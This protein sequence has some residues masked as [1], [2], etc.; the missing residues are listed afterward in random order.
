M[1]LSTNIM[2]GIFKTISNQDRTQVPFKA[3]KNWE[4]SDA[5]TLQTYGSGVMTAIKPNKNVY[6]GN[7]VPIGVIP[8]SLDYASNYTNVY[9]NEATASVLWYSLNHLYYKGDGQPFDTFG[10]ANH[11]QIYR[12]IY[13]DANVISLAQR[14]IG[15]GIKPGSFTFQASSS[16]Y[17]AEF[18]F[19][20]VD[21]GKGNLID[22]NISSSISNQVFYIR[23]HEM[24]YEKDWIAA[25]I[26]TVPVM[27]NSGVLKTDSSNKELITTY[28]NTAFTNQYSASGSMWAQAAHF[29]RTGYIRIP[30][31]DILNF[32]QSNDYSISFAFNLLNPTSSFTFLNKQA[33]GVG[34]TLL[35]NGTISTG[36]KSLNKSQYPYSIYY[37]PD[38]FGTNGTITAACS[39]GA[40]TTTV[41]TPIVNS[42]V[43]KRFVGL[44][45]SGSLLSIYLDGVLIDSNNI[46]TNGNIHN[47]ADIFIGCAGLDVTGSAINGMHG[48][49]SDFIVFNRALLDEEFL[50][51]AD[52][53]Y[54]QSTS[55]NTNI[56]GN[57]FYEHGMVVISDPRPKYTTF[58]FWTGSLANNSTG[59]AEPISVAPGYID[60]FYFTYAST[61]TIYENEVTCRLNQDEFNFT[62]N[63]TIREDNDTNSQVPKDF[64]SNPAFSP[65]ITTIGLYNNVGQ[66][67][68]VAKLHN[69]VKKRDNVDLNV[70]VRYD[71]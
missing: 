27:V 61:V 17:P 57:I 24:E 1:S 71:F 42:S 10:N 55:I 20:L 30:N 23:M 63:P 6:S 45:K 59:A 29:N 13:T 51:L 22:T 9:G 52:N 36:D 48:S 47:D 40:S 43:Q 60:N 25:P 39:T 50:Q 56:V 31:N 35:K 44:S 58:R 7:V 14:T 37:T 16:T 54:N 69:P 3:Y 11:G 67:V 5:N 46:D 38:T 2:N 34:S 28:T 32:K 65:Y 18:S 21:D 62:M 26:T 66:L 68:A 12:R 53:T 4:Y 49:V 33:T 8:S 15:E 70:V 41:A 19:N 64:V